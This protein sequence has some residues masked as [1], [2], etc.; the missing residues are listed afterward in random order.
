[1]SR[2]IDNGR[3]LHDFFKRHESGRALY[4]DTYMPLRVAKT[5]LEL[6]LSNL[7]SSPEANSGDLLI[8][9]V[10]LRIMPAASR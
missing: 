6:L 10:S 9:P 2:Q 3:Q 8:N 1:M 4:A 5:V 7:Q